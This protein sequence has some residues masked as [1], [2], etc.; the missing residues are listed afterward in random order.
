MCLNIN[1]SANYS[2]ISWKLMFTF[3]HTMQML[4]DAYWIPTLPLLPCSDTT[5]AYRY[6]LEGNSSEEI[7]ILT[8]EQMSEF[9][10]LLLGIS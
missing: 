2:W 10:N 4:I 9:H 6:G 3:H 5:E 8:G 1:L 7:N